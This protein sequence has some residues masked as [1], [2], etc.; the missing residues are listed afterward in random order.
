MFRFRIALPASAA[1]LLCIG[2][3]SA[4]E[5]TVAPSKPNPADGAAAVPALNYSSAFAGY[6]KAADDPA[7]GWKESNELSHR[8]GG[9][10]SYARIARE[11]EAAASGAA[12]GAAMPDK[13]AMPAGHSHGKH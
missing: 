7:P 12:S 10:R 6:R 2:W 11:P 8:V 4:A 5:P 9:W 13:A 3:A 1:A